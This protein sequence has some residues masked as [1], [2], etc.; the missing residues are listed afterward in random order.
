MGLAAT[1]LKSDDK[2]ILQFEI[3]NNS[4]EMTYTLKLDTPLEG[5]HN[6]T[7]HITNDGVLSI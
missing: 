7:F 1:E 4:D 6:N 2:Q 5:M 3:T